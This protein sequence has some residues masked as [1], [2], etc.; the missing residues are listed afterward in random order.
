LSCC[1]IASMRFRV[2]SDTV[3]LPRKARDTVGCDTPASCAI[4]N[5]VAL[6]AIAGQRLSQLLPMS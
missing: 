1:A 2:C 6:P 5:D 4:S 3:E